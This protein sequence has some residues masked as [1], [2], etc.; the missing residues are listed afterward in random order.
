MNYKD[1]TFFLTILTCGCTIIIRL[2]NFTHF[3][4][5]SHKI[6]VLDKT[7]RNFNYMQINRWKGILYPPEFKIEFIRMQDLYSSIY[8]ILPL[9]HDG[10][11]LLSYVVNTG[12]Y[13]CRGFC[14]NKIL[15]SKV[16]LNFFMICLFQFTLIINYLTIIKRTNHQTTIKLSRL[17]LSHK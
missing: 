6:F 15:N 11:T 10:Y 2:L 12:Y 17:F 9:F 16:L 4:Y 7:N 1:N 3:F 5:I 8:K 14:Q 13:F